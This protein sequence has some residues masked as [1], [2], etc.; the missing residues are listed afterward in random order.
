MGRLAAIAEDHYR[1]YLPTAY[2]SIKDKPTF[3]RALET[4][5]DQQIADLADAMEQTE[6]APP[7]E[8]FL[9]KAGRLSMIRRDA[10]SQIVRELLLPEPEKQP[11]QTE[12]PADRELAAAVGEFHAERA[13][14]LEAAQQEP[15]TQ[16]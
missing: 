3:F 8:T 10:E 14:L 2:A 15:P 1:K 16:Q 12:S 6:Q 7:G 4:E 11:P 13:N 9:Q 5:A